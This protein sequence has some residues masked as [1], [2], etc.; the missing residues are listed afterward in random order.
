[1]K[2]YNV[3]LIPRSNTYRFIALVA[4][5]KNYSVDYYIEERSIPHITICQ[6]SSDKNC[7][8]RTWTNICENLDKVSV[9]IAFW[10]YS[11]ITFDNKI[12]WLSLI[13]EPSIELHK[14]FNLV[15]KYITP[16]R[17][18]AY[19]PHLTLLNYKK[20]T[21]SFNK[22]ELVQEVLIK[23]HFDLILGECDNIGQ[24]KKIIFHSANH[25]KAD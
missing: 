19:D 11:N 14:M 5:K 7:I 23:D 24:L 20:N 15:S 9:K 12:Y 4:E 1:M 17:L 3:A 18:D 21:L 25:N 10:R 16:I 2:K 6:F 13:P 8:K 22:E